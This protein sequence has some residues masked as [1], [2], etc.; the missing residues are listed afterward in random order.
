MGNAGVERSASY[1]YQAT[2][3]LG[4]WHKNCCPKAMQ[5]AIPETVATVN[6]TPD[7]GDTSSGIFISFTANF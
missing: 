6:V 5:F 4:P 2:C 1:V 3:P 7:T